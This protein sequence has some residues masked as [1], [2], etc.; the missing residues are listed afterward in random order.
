MLH[1]LYYIVL[2]NIIACYIILVII[3]AAAVASE[4]DKWGQHYGATANVMFC[5]TEILV[6]THFPECQ[7]EPVFRSGKINYFCS[8]PMSVDPICS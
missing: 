2:Y 5:F 6:G 4:R 1:M 7:D 8:G 3:L